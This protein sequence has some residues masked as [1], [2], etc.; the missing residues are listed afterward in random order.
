MQKCSDPSGF[1]ENCMGAPYSDQDG[2]IALA[3]NNSSNYIL[4]SNYS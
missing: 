3:S 1:L 2:R 4:I